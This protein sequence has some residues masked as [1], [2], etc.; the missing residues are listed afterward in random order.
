MAERAGLFE[1]LFRLEERGGVRRY[2][3][4]GFAFRSGRLRV[5][6]PRLLWPRITGRERVSADGTQLRVSVRVSVP[7]VGFLV[8]YGG[9]LKVERTEA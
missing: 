8:A 4:V 3:Q 2:R 1:I 7:L 5:P 6:L 9:L